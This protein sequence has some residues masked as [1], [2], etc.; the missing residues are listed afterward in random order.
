MGADQSLD[1]TR[2]IQPIITARSQQARAPDPEVR[3]EFEKAMEAAHSTSR[4]VLRK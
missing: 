4:P 3:R 2:A 1:A